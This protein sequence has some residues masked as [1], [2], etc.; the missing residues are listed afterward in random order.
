MHCDIRE[1][2]HIGLFHK[3]LTNHKT[4]PILPDF[5]LHSY[6]E[7]LQRSAKTDLSDV[8]NDITVIVCGRHR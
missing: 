1:L 3:L 6:F 2:L 7:H 8:V 4:M 5:T